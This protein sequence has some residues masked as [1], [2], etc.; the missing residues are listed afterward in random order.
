MLFI[1]MIVLGI[2]LIFASFLIVR[3][4]YMLEQVD[5][6]GDIEVDSPNYPRSA[7]WMCNLGYLLILGAL[8]GALLV[9]LGF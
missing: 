5:W 6:T 2:A 4:H 3:R 1:G 8:G 9:W 7:K